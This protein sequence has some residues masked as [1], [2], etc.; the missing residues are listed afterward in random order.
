MIEQL[1]PEG[2]EYKKF[3]DCCEYVRGITYNKGQEE[4][5]ERAEAWSVL[6]ANN[7]TLSNNTLNF[8]DVKRVSTSVKIKESQKLKKG[9]ILICAGSGSKE[10][11]GK[12]AYIF[13]DIPYTFGGFMAV[14]RSNSINSRF[15]FHILTGGGFKEYLGMA[16]NST[17]I[18]NLNSSI[19][20]NF[21]IPLPPLP[22][23]SEIVRILDKFSL[24]EAELEAEL[25]CRKRQYEYYR[26]NLLNFKQIGG[27]SAQVIWM[28]LGEVAEVGTG[29]CNGN[30]AEDEGKYPF[31]VRSKIIKRKND[32]QFDEEAII[33]PGEGG[34]GDI[35]HY[36]NGKYALHQRVYRIHFKTNGI[37]VKFVYYYMMA[38]FKKF[39]LKKAVCATV[40]SIRKPM[41]E[42]FLI[43]VPPLAEQER[44]ASILDRFE[45]LTT[46]ISQGLP[47]EIAA[48]RQ[49]YEY[50]RDM[51]L[52]FKRK[53]A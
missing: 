18:N 43:P 34:I 6:R 36:I 26:D 38:C 49:Q 19:I 52:T 10:H 4:Q 22:I 42:D 13:E 12:V 5:D 47:A 1:C 35:F 28:K 7:I 48:R 51:L 2:V 8:M 14:I 21:S 41:I 50:Y 11:V 20:E 31:F 37:N 16:L 45:A 24:L 25:D 46:D 53:T 39:I 33:I 23:Q 32:Y 40:T 30:E 44:I 29:S 15:L 17:T 3:A 27:G 9:D